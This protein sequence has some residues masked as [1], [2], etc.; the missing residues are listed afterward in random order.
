MTREEINQLVQ[1]LGFYRKETP[2]SPVPEEFQLAP[3]QPL[4]G[5]DATET[6]HGAEGKGAVGEELVGRTFYHPFGVGLSGQVPSLPRSHRQRSLKAE[7]E[8]GPERKG[9]G[10]GTELGKRSRRNDQAVSFD[11]FII[12]RC[13]SSHVAFENRS[14]SRLDDGSKTSRTM[15]VES[16]YVK[17]SGTDGNTFVQ[18]KSSYSSSSSKKV[19]S[20]FEREDESPGRASSLAALERRQ[21]EKK[22]ELLKTQS[23]PKTT[24]SQ[25]RKAMIEK[26]EKEG[27]SPANPAVSRVAVQRSAS[28]GVPN[29][30]SIKQMLLDWC[31]AKTRGYDHVDIQ[32]FSSSWSDGMAFCALVHNFFPDAFDYAQLSPQDRRRNFEM[33]F[34]AAEYGQPVINLLFGKVAKFAGNG[35]D[36]GL[37]GQRIVS[38]QGIS[39]LTQTL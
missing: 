10:A 33:A 29:A 4:P 32:N 35:G 34:S 3:A 20:I 38:L 9:G 7:E 28:F 8:E 17:R 1:E 23:V 24:A 31:R 2:D 39:L 14:Q 21:A 27:G 22:K 19:G 15:T 30:N 25:A 18:S 16:S 36:C 6:K 11:A 5:P 26:L 13:K 37:E 12:P